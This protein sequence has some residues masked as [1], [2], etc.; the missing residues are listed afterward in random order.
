[1]GDPYGSDLSEDEEVLDSLLLQAYTG[2]LEGKSEVRIRPEGDETEESGASEE[3][4][5]SE[6]DVPL[7]PNGLSRDAI[8]KG[9]ISAVVYDHPDEVEE[10]EIKEKRPRKR[11][12]DD[13]VINA[14]PIIEEATPKKKGVCYTP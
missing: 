7:K 1:M 13:V 9:I 11:T 6:G 4:E 12:I 14:T 5:S 8:L 2:T 10:G 3:E